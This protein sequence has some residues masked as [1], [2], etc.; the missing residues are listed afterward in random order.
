M[1]RRSTRAAGVRD[2]RPYPSRCGRTARVSE[3]RDGDRVTLAGRVQG[4]APHWLLSDETGDVE[5]RPADGSEGLH[6]GDIVEMEG[7]WNAAWFEASTV[8]ILAPSLSAPGTLSPETRARLKVRARLLS[9]IRRF[10]DVRGFTE[11]ETPLL[12]ASPGTEPHLTAFETRYRDGCQDRRLFMHP[13]PEHAMKRLLGAGFERIFQICKAFR[14]EAAGA[15]H[16]PEFTILEWYRAYADYEAIMADSEALVCALATAING[17]PRLRY[18]DLTV[19]VT[20]PWER[21]SVG[22]AFARY[23]GVEIGPDEDRDAFIRSA[24]EKGHLSVTRED[25]YASAY[26]KVFLDSVEGRLGRHRPTILVDYPAGMA[27]LAKRK[28]E[29]P[30]LA[31]R[32]EIYIAGV[33]LANGFTELNDPSEQRVRF[34]AELL[35]RRSNGAAAYPIDEAFLEAMEAGIPPAGGVAVGVDRL[36]MLLTGA[37]T[38]GDVIAFPLCEPSFGGPF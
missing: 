4:C 10:F 29:A 17:G 22:E 6:A 7:V 20:P 33:E 30:H 14:H 9:R 8:R 35:E 2:S 24:R 3:L 26:F 15:L 18:G 21:L 16:H 31:E 11:V 27:A 23:A 19:D 12:V 28:P 32:F 5:V 37:K 38:I 1:R 13:S 25:D 36:L 34:E